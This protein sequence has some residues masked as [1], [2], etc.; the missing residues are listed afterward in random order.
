[1]NAEENKVFRG[2]KI[3][4]EEGNFILTKPKNTWDMN[5]HLYS[6]L[7][8]VEYLIDIDDL[9]EGNFKLNELMD[10]S[11]AQHNM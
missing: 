1:M 6:L 2:G 8:R 10:D 11:Y 3:I 4:Q 9:P 7:E 5:Y